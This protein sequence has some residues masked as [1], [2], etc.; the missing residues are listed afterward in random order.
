MVA[1][2]PCHPDQA[3]AKTRL[4]ELAEVTWEPANGT[5]TPVSVPINS[6]NLKRFDQNGIE[7]VIN[8]CTGEAFA[9]Q[10][11]CSQMSGI[12]SSG[13]DKQIAKLVSS[14]TIRK[15]EIDTEHGIKVVNLI[16]ANLVFKWAITDNPELAEA[17]G[18]AGATVYIHQLARFK[19]S[20]DAITKTAPAP[21]APPIP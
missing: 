19:V 14:D 8:A 6:T 1:N 15:A 12:S 20:S 7:L 18:T 13:I 2:T 21:T 16:P 5:I 17:V 11:G 9:S 10:T 3:E 4:A